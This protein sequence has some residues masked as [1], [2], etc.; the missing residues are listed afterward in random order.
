M[1]TIIILRDRYDDPMKYS[2]DHY[3]VRWRTAGYRVLDHIGPKDVPAGD[4]VVV[5]IDASVIPREY[6]DVINRFPKSIN[7]RILDISRRNYSQIL[8]SE[9]DNYTGPALVKTNANYGGSPE[10]ETKRPIRYRSMIAAGKVPSLIEIATQTPRILKN[11]LIR[12]GGKLWKR[13]SPPNWRT[14]ETL[15]PYQ[16]PVFE[17]IESV[18]T[19]V[20]DNPHLVVEN[21]W[22]EKRTGSTRVTTMSFLETKKL[23]E[24]CELQTRWLSSRLA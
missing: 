18:P 3:I 9:A 2:I 24:G 21:F 6:L 7:G 22:E 5:H 14:L 23:P 1:K 17:N 12:L 8:L 16:Y 4:L 20:W 11:R 13:I 19:G 10:Y 15:N